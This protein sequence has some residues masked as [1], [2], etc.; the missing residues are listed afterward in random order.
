MKFTVILL[1]TLFSSSFSNAVNLCCFLIKIAHV[2][3]LF[4]TWRINVNKKSN[5]CN[6]MQ[7]FIHCKTSLHVSGVTAPI[8]TSAVTP[9]TCRV[10]LQWINICILLHLL[11]F[12]FTLNYDARNHELK[13]YDESNFI[14]MNIQFSRQWTRHILHTR[15]HFQGLLC[16]TLYN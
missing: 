15:M 7:I 8:I 12:L 6:N 1:F 11:D 13:V 10:V 16:C 4:K 14:K 5:R 3:Y 2:L 9:E